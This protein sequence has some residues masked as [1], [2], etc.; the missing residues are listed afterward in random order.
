V[1][2]TGASGCFVWLALL[3]V[4]LVLAAHAGSMISKVERLEADIML[5]RSDI[6]WVK[7]DAKA[8]V[9]AVRKKMQDAI[10]VV[11][12]DFEAMKHRVE[13]FLHLE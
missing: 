13:K 9:E 8:D 6:A 2:K 11:R 3:C 4:F 5:I 12:D 7:E 1:D 10:D